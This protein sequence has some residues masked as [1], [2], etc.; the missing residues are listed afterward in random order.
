MLIEVPPETAAGETRVAG[1]PEAARKLKALGHRLR[2][3]SGTSVAAIVPNRAYEAVG[4]GICD[5]AAALW[6]ELVLKVRAPVAEDTVSAV[7]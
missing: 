2:V 4:A 7:E 3:R 6:A 5:A 1:A